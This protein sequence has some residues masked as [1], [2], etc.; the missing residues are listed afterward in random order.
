MDKTFKIAVIGS[1]ISGLVSAYLLSR[2]HVVTLFEQGNYFGGH[3]HTIDLEIEEQTIPVD[4]GF[5]VFNEVTYPNFTRLLKEL[6][7]AYHDSSMSFSVKDEKTGLEYNGT[8]INRLFAQ[9]SNLFSPR[10]YGMIRD[11]LRFNKNAKRFAQ[12][13]DATTTVGEFL[14]KGNYGQAFHQWYLIPMASA[15]W[16]SIPYEIYQF[17]AKFFC[18][19]FHH[20]RMLEVND[21][22]VWKTITDGSRTY[23]Q[24]M[25]SQM[26]TSTRLHCKVVGVSRETEGVRLTLS[27][28]EQLL[29]DKVVIATH[30]DQALAM[31]TDPSTEE[32]SI[33]SSI[34]Y[35]PNRAY[36][37]TDTSL[38]PKRKLAWGAWN[39]FLPIHSKNVATLTYQMN[40]LQGLPTSTPIQI[41]L[42]YPEGIDET[43]IL[44]EIEYHHPQYTVKTYQ[45]QNRRAE[46]S[47][48]RNTYYCGA[49]WYYGFHEDG[50]NSALDVV[51]ALGVE[52]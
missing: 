24:K 6:Q 15:I 13:G 39:S 27:T 18:Q 1:G 30:S 50:V 52:W 45:A 14:R 29:F 46:I 19:F 40:I 20:H 41:T 51:K 16:S 3:T 32:K 12:E 4:T 33:L 17:P 21:R 35:Q 5:I 22:P 34:R 47:G 7:V 2:K 25:L 49:Y 37:H 38:L 11:I 8:S 26:K 48:A 43:K 42:N 23:V 44:R 10:F 36:V 31:L 28:G 9:R